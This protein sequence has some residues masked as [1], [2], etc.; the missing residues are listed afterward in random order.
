MYCKFTICISRSV[1]DN[2]WSFP[3]INQETQIIFILKGDR[4]N[5]SAMFKLSSFINTPIFNLFKKRKKFFNWIILYTNCTWPGTGQ[6]RFNSVV[7]SHLQNR[8]FL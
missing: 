1:I 5:N 8:A 3:G 2:K 7:N 6:A 4:F